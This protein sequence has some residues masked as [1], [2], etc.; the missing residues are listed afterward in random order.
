M[1][2]IRRGGSPQQA[3]V[4]RLLFAAM[5]EARSCERFR[6]LPQ[7]I[8]DPELKQFYYELMVSEA[9]HYTTF[10]GLARKYGKEVVDVDKRW[11]DFL[12]YEAEIITKYGKSETIHG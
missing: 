8:N 9:T 2:C 7:E 4:D 3:M 5:I 10:I 11:E 12:V 1:A 6:L